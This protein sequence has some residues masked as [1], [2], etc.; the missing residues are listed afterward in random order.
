MEYIYSS[1]CSYISIH[2]PSLLPSSFAPSPSLLSLY[3]FLPLPPYLL[4]PSIPSPSLPPSP[5]LPPSLSL[6]PSLPPPSTY[7]N[8]IKHS[9]CSHHVLK[10][11]KSLISII[12]RVSQAFLIDFVLQTGDEFLFIGAGGLASVAWVEPYTG[13]LQT[14]KKKEKLLSREIFITFSQLWSEVSR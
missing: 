2:T 8:T 5:F 7:W 13:V 9:L 6:P 11:I 3:P 1:P 14:E 10:N 12:Q 4:P